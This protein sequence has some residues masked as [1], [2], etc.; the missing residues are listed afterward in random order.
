[1]VLTKD[2]ILF[3][4]RQRELIIQVKQVTGTLHLDA[5]CKIIESI[6]IVCVNIIND[7]YN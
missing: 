6:E 2:S 7:Y 4:P 5:L 3:L 1:M